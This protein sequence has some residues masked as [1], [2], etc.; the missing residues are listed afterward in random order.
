MP[1]SFLPLSLIIIV[2]DHD[3][4]HTI[5]KAFVKQS[6]ITDHKV[7]DFMHANS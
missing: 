1:I 7:L 3:K 5:N 4:S 6:L 2:S